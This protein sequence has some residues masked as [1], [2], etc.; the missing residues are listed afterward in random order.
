MARSWFSKARNVSSA[1]YLVFFC[2]RLWNLPLVG[3][4]AEHGRQLNKVNNSR[5][6]FKI[7]R[8]V[9]GSRTFFTNS[10]NSSHL[11]PRRS[12]LPV[13]SCTVALL[14]A[15]FFAKTPLQ[16]KCLQGRN[17]FRDSSRSR[18]GGKITV[19]FARSAQAILDVNDSW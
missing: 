9:A 10:S 17:L 11:A 4:L 12:N 19:F 3:G 2:R 13:L 7:W 14:S 5:V 16:L 1:L 6:G 8:P 15:Q 18:C